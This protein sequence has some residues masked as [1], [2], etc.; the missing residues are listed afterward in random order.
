MADADGRTSAAFAVGPSLFSPDR[1][2]P[3]S[4]GYAVIADALLHTLARVAEARGWI[5]GQ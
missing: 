2:H 4:D 1:F 3:S 5:G